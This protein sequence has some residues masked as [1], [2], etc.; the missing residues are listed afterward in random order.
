MTRNTGEIRHSLLE[1]LVARLEFETDVFEPARDIRSSRDRHLPGREPGAHIGAR[2]SAVTPAT[3]VLLDCGIS[4]R[5]GYTHVLWVSLSAEAIL[6][7]YAAERLAEII[8][9]L[10]YVTA[11]EWEGQDRLHV[12]APGIDW[13][14]VL[15][16]A[17]HAV[18]SL[19][20]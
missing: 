13:D 12:R 8:C 19:F 7:S 14:D 15:G 9:A 11:Y 20:S 17:R 4:R 1:D 16:D 18:D 2:S 5:D 10:D 3:T 6:G